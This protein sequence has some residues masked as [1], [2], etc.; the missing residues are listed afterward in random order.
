M[1][2]GRFE[3]METM[4]GKPPEGWTL[5]TTLL[6]EGPDTILCEVECWLRSGLA[7]HEVKVVTNDHMGIPNTRVSLGRITHKP[8]G[9]RIVD[10]T[11]LDDAV[12]GAERIE[13]VTKWNEIKSLAEA[14]SDRYLAVRSRLETMFVPDKTIAHW[15]TIYRP[16]E[17]RA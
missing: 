8:T 12:M 11:S 3:Y 16:Q 1:R 2:Q 17:A 7:V 9:F 10:F 15:M 5:D 6:R 4:Y 13:H 14:T